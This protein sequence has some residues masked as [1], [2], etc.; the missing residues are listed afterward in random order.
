MID[1]FG[2]IS[3]DTITINYFKNV[4]LNIISPQTNIDTLYN[5]LVVYGTVSEINAGDMI[6]LKLNGT[7]QDSYTFIS[8]TDTKWALPINLKGQNDYITVEL[9]SKLFGSAAASQTV[10][11]NYFDTPSIKITAPNNLYETNSNSIILRGTSY[12]TLSG[13]KINLYHLLLYHLIRIKLL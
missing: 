8:Y 11:V 3:E 4:S 10:Y 13:E 1:T 5:S 9:N 2:T 6:I 12:N 7:Q